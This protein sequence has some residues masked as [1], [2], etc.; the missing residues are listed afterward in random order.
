MG[1]QKRNF[2]IKMYTRTWPSRLLSYVFGLTYERIWDAKNQ[3][4]VGV[5]QFEG[6]SKSAATC[7]DG[8]YFQLKSG[9]GESIRIPNTWWYASAIFGS[10]DRVLAT[11]QEKWNFVLSIS[12]SF[13]HNEWG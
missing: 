3:R 5:R 6:V 1:Y 9:R 8:R 7:E 2:L 13:S 11:M 12:Y 4:S 10:L